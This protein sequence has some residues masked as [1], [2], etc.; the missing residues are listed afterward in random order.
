VH[1]LVHLT[2]YAYL[3]SAVGR[4]RWDHVRCIIFKLNRFAE[5][6]LCLYVMDISLL[7]VRLD[8]LINTHKQLSDTI[9]SY[10]RTACLNAL[11]L[12]S[13]LYVTEHFSFIKQA[14]LLQTFTLTCC[15]YYRT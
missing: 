10:H 15:H 9:R 13:F 11:H 3:F 5:D 4:L 2:I 14:V 12:S 7:N 1:V 8:T 6:E